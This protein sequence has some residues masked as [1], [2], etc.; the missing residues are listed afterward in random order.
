M[1]SISENKNKLPL[2]IINNLLKKLLDTKLSKLESKNKDEMNKIKSLSQNS[3][4]IINEIQSIN[5]KIK[6]KNKQKKDIIKVY[7]PINIKEKNENII[8]IKYYFNNMQIN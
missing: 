4:I 8:K 5:K 7:H 3:D 1:S 6:A 2:E